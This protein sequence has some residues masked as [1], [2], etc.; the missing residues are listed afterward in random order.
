MS[1]RKPGLRAPGTA[2]A[3]AAALTF[4]L[5]QAAAAA[6]KLRYDVW[7][8]GARVLEVALTLRQ[9]EESYRVTLDALL[10]GVP[11]WFTDYR[12]AAE[13]EGRLGEAGPAPVI[14]RQEEV[15]DPKDGTKWVQLVFNAD[16]LPTVTTDGDPA[17]IGRGR[18]RI[19]ER[20]KLGSQDPLSAVLSLLMQ[21]AATGTCQGA[22]PVYDGKRRFDLKVQ[23]QGEGEVRKGFSIYA[24]AA[25]I[26]GVTFHPVA[27]YR[28]DGK[29]KGRLPE[30]V[31]VFLASPS[32]GL[33]LVPVRMESEIE[34]GAVMIHLVGVTETP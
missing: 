16:G 15:S 5:P 17:S 20:Q 23:D 22:A 2:A 12:L 33:P 34:Y 26:C 19:T 29:D 18:S 28:L 9:E 24:G 1:I 14:Y 21:T 10:V 13:A 30:E 31:K 3:L 32:E 25:R 4:A 27:G 11:A 6:T 8:G 7:S